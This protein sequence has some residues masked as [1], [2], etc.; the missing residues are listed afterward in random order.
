MG[1]L[2]LRALLGQ[3]IYIYIYIVSIRTAEL[4]FPAVMP[5]AAGSW[6]IF[7]AKGLHH[8]GLDVPR[9]YEKGP[10]KNI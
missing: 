1:E 10:N 4:R 2:L 3:M 8:S 7:D 6:C 9:M 5:F